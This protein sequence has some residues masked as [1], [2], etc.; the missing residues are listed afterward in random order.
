ML[1]IILESVVLL[2]KVLETFDIEKKYGDL[3]I[4]SNIN[5]VVNEGDFIA[6]MGPS[7]SGKSTLLYVLSGLEKSTNGKV[8]FDEK[9]ITKLN[10]KDLYD[11][12]LNKMGFVFQQINLLKNLNVMDNIII[13][14]YMSKKY[15]NDV[16][17]QK[18]RDYLKAMGIKK[19]EQK[20]LTNIS[21]GEMQR[22]A[23]ARA[24]IN[25]PDIIFL[26]EPTGAL[27]SKAAFEMLNILNNLNEQGKTLLMVTHDLKVAARASKILYLSDGKIKDTLEL[28]KYTDE[29]SKIDREKKVSKYLLEMGW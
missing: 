12:R 17:N 25:N 26:D 20:E 16:I 19:I 9:D 2:K 18:A 1:N 24:L 6:I 14:G 15:R 3:K 4:L 5:M 23:I 21:G 7:G 13:P 28:G 11:T 22:V 10:E 29:K 27:N 8:I